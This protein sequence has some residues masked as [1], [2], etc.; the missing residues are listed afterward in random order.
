M[1]NEFNV[2]AKEIIQTENWTPEN[3]IKLLSLP[4]EDAREILY[5]A[6]KEIKEKFVGK[7]V[8]FR[9]L[10]ELSNICAKDCYYCGIRKGNSKLERYTIADEDVLAAVKFAHQN[11][12][13]SVVIQAGEIAS[14]AFTQKI[15][16]LLKKIHAETKGQLH[17]TLS[18]GEQSLE[19]YQR[20]FDAGAHRYLLRIET[21]NKELYK[22]IH[23][24]DDTH[25]FDRRVECL[26]F[27]KK[28]G[29]QMGSGIMVGFP[30]QSLEDIANDILFLQ[31][32]DI[33]M[34]GL[35]PY[36]EHE[37][38]PLFER[39]T[40]LLPL[41]ER[42]DLTLK[43]IAILRLM[44]KDINIASATALQA[45]DPAGREKA[46]GWGTNV[47]MPNLTPTEFREGYKLYDN[48]PCLD[49]DRTKCQK[50]LEGRIVMYGHEVGYGEW[51]D[52]QHYKKKR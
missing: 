36:I 45:I 3:I 51:G 46:L 11:N 31:K 5:P 19:T 38:T 32:I 4:M 39:R 25:N 2:E 14:P 52:S 24:Q 17:V 8:Y 44:M 20:W 28:V 16:E 1:S 13:A 42:F 6:A 22:T 7:K 23:P 48:K 26:H 18:L 43:T 33:D 40:E 9:G 12:Y 35:G 50:C 30:G 27:L 41:Q 49:E 21:S 29:Y 15:E 10:V 34:C 47:I 37:D